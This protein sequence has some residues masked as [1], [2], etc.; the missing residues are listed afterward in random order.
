MLTEKCSVLEEENKKK[1]ENLLRL[2]DQV[3]KNEKETLVTK[4]EFESMRI[5]RFY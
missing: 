1:Q 4:Q 3:G 2:V 5:V